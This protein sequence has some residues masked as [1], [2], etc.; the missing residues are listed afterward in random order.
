MLASLRVHESVYCHA[1][2]L[3]GAP[4]PGVLVDTGYGFQSQSH[5]FWT[6]SSSL[7]YVIE[8][9]GFDVRQGSDLFLG[10]SLFDSTHGQF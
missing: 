5:P 10:D 9:I 3:W 7:K 1:H 2:I 6:R 8:K 4:D